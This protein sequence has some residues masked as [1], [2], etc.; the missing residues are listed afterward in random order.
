M[1]NLGRRDILKLGGMLAASGLPVDQ[2]AS[3]HAPD[4]M[5]KALEPVQQTVNFI[6]DGLHLTPQAYA[7]ILQQYADSGELHPDNYSNGGVIQELEQ[8]FA[9]LL[10]KESA[11]FMPTG[12]LA[13]HVA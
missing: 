7:H 4:S 2:A 11:V 6:Y 5:L 13:N 10:G 3:H 8:T 9:R 12:T 1:A